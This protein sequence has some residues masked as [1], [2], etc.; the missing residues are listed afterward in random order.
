ME[1]I[2]S[3]TGSSIRRHLV[4]LTGLA[5]LS[6]GVYALIWPTQDSS[7]LLQGSCIKAGLVLLAFW[8]A[9]PQLDRLPLW[10]VGSTTCGLLF[11]AVRPQILLSVV[12]LAIVLSPLLGILWLLRPQSWAKFRETPTGKI[13]VRLIA[14]A[15]PSDDSTK[16]LTAKGQR[17]S[18][19]EQNDSLR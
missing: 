12:R 17:R 9:F 11:L 5:L 13:V 4:G 7:E 3:R 19:S 8:L 10:A 6:L 18:P 14:L 1:T 15:T 16:R 2:D